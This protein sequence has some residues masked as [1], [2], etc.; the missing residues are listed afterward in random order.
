MTNRYS[1]AIAFRNFVSFFSIIEATILSR[2]KKE[3][4]ERKYPLTLIFL[5]DFL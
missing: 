3:S 2:K 4:E 5:F 1:G